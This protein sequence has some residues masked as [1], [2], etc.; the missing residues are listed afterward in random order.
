MKQYDAII[1]G[2]GQAANP[3]AL[4]LAALGWKV[5]LV[6]KKHIGGTCINEGCTPTKTMVASAKAAF[7][8]S[9]AKEYG[10]E[11]G[12]A[13]VDI[14]A[15]L[16]RKNNIVN[17]FRDGL[18]SGLSTNENVTIFFGEAVFIG[19][20]EIAVTDASNNVL[21]YSAKYFFINTGARPFIPGIKGL[22]S[23]PFLTST[24]LLDLQE[25]P[26]HLI[27]IGAGPVAIEFAQI[28]RRFGSQVTI[29][30]R[31]QRLLLNEDPDVAE[32]IKSILEDEGISILFKTNVEET[33]M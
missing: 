12:T 17:R 31:S 24:S 22:D 6:E 3:L 9:R 10:L 21:Q 2:S 23:V 28:Y 1:I 14:M 27:I 19:D 4:R 5:A 33:G 16:N 18:Q 32:E 20:K 13:R 26:G 8:I 7:Q 25:I 15:V 11:A 30:C 29:I